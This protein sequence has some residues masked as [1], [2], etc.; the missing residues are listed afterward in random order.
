MWRLQ[1]AV[2]RVTFAGRWLAARTI[3]VGLSVGVLFALAVLAP[4]TASAEV[5]VPVGGVIICGGGGGGPGPTPQ[6]IPPPPTPNP[7]PPG[8]DSDHFLAYERTP[9]GGWQETDLTALLGAQ[10]VA[11]LPRSISAEYDP[12]SGNVET[13]AEGSNGHLI[14][15]WQAPGS[16]WASGDITSQVG[17]T[18]I[19]GAPDAIATSTGVDV[20][21]LSSS[22]QQLLEFAWT[23]SAG[24]RASVVGST[25]LNTSLEVSGFMSDPRA[26]WD[27]QNVHVY[28]SEITG[29]ETIPQITEF[30]SASGGP[31][32]RFTL[33]SAMDDPT[34]VLVGSTIHVVGRQDIPCTSACG[35]F[36]YGTS[37]DLLDL[38]E[39]A[40][41]PGSVAVTNLTAAAG[42]TPLPASLS[43]DPTPVDYGGPQ[44]YTEQSTARNSSGGDIPLL[45]EYF[46]NGS[47]QWTAVTIN[48]LGGGSAIGEDGLGDP[49]V[50]VDSSNDLNVLIDNAGA[51]DNGA[52]GT[53][54]G[55][56]QLYRWTGSWQFTDVTSATASPQITQY[57]A[58]AATP[59]GYLYAF[60][61]E[62]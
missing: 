23:P 5:C 60:A 56:L 18:T 33:T 40:S 35:G 36:T 3:P 17:G 11:G 42:I 20:F 39:P 13:Y 21:A 58:V 50:A 10:T 28:I 27:G 19:N 26:V 7:P 59:Q 55:D 57:P 51:P 44:F 15:F 61:A 2:A 41:S 24:W 46:Q 37:G 62:A 6:P 45:E 38:T 52:D 31:W 49:A 16:T 4:A 12:V 34:P 53:G 48:G 8:P 54:A 22:R 43:H 47:G 25:S 29:T 14:E 32:Q 1:A 30:F 9:G